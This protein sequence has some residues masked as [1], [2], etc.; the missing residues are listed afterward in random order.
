VW[1]VEG[2]GLR[3][4]GRGGGGGPFRK[5]FEEHWKLSFSKTPTA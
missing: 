5:R 1:C 2:D 4:D 3:E